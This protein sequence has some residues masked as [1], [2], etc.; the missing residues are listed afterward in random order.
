VAKNNSLL[1]CCDGMKKLKAMLLSFSEY[2]AVVEYVE[3]CLASGSPISAAACCSL[4]SSGAG[5]AVSRNRSGVNVDAVQSIYLMATARRMKKLSYSFDSGGTSSKI[6]EIAEVHR[7]C[8]LSLTV[9]GTMSS[10]IL[11]FLGRVRGLVQYLGI[12]VRHGILTVQA[13]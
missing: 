7:P 10:I 8:G 9:R 6:G 2:T 3:A 4:L 12:C 11:F 13:C 1:R 5:C